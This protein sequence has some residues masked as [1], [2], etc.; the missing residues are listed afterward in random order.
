MKK[1]AIELIGREGN[2]EVIREVPDMLYDYLAELAI[3]LQDT[4]D[5]APQMIVTVVEEL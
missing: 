3:E 4:Y 2:T 5:E 1:I